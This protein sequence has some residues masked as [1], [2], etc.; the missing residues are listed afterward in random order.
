MPGSPTFAKSVGVSF[1]EG[2]GVRIFSQGRKGEEGDGGGRL[3]EVDT[4]IDNLRSDARDLSTQWQLRFGSSTWVLISD[5]R[6]YATRP[7]LFLTI[8]ERI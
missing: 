7:L 4:P 2:I 5:F 8:S 1:S 6:M 3:F